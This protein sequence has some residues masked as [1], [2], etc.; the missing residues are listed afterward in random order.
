MRCP[1]ELATRILGNLSAAKRRELLSDEAFLIVDEG[2][3]IVNLK[4]DVEAERVIQLLNGKQI[5]GRVMLAKQDKFAQKTVDSNPQVNL[6][7]AQQRVCQ[8]DGSSSEESSSS[9]ECHILA[10]ETGVFDD[11]HWAHTSLDE[12]L[13]SQQCQERIG[14][15]IVALCQI[16]KGVES[17]EAKSFESNIENFESKS[18]ES[19]IENIEGKGFESSIENVEKAYH[20]IEVE[21]IESCRSRLR[22]GP[23]LR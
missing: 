1:R 7:E 14:P 13:S 17:V 4:T 3:A 16:S 20:D 8:L 5:G 15:D 2:T 19:N 22:E 21:N 6:S 23:K 11:S 9:A 12:R 18:F 10:V